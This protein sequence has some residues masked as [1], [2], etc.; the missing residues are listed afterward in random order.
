M[1]IN[2]LC[3]YLL[4]CSILYSPMP[5]GAVVSTNVTVSG[6]RKWAPV[7]STRDDMY[8]PDSCFNDLDADE[9]CCCCRA[10]PCW[11]LDPPACNVTVGQLY[12]EYTDI[13]GSSIF[14]PSGNYTLYEAIH[15]N[16]YLTRFPENMCDFA[17]SLVNVDFSYNRLADISAIRCLKKL[18]TLRLDANRIS[19][20]SNATFSDMEYL[21]IVSLS[22]NIIE[23][24][25]PNT[26]KI[27]NGTV[28]MINFSHNIIETLD[29]TNIIIPGPFC[30]ISYEGCE[31]SEQTNVLDYK[32]NEYNFHGPG[33][34]NLQNTKGKAFLNFSKLGVDDYTQ[35]GNYFK[36]SIEYDGSSIACDCNL[37]PFLAGLGKYASNYWPRLDNNEN[38]TCESPENM[39]GRNLTKIYHGQKF[40]DLTCDLPNCP[41]NCKCTDEPSKDKVIVKCTKQTRMPDFIPVGYWNNYRVEL[42]LSDHSNT[43]SHFTDTS[44]TNRL[45]V[46]NFGDNKIR[47][48]DNAMESLSDNIV[49]TLTNQDMKTIPTSFYKL[50]PNKIDFGTNPVDCSCDNIWVGDWIRN[51]HAHGKLRCSTSYGVFPAEKVTSDFL[52]CPTEETFPIEVIYVLTSLLLLVLVMTSLAYFYK[53]EIMLLKRKFHN[54]RHIQ[55][56]CK[57]DAMVTFSEDNPEVFK[58]MERI[59]HTLRREGYSLFVPFF[60]LIPGGNRECQIAEGVSQSRNYIV[61]Y[62]HKYFHH[63]Y[64]IQEFEIL[65]KHFR[66]DTTKNIIVINFDSLESSEINV[67]RIRAFRKLREDLNFIER[68]TKLFERLKR[69][70]GPPTRKPD[71]EETLV[72][73][74]ESSNDETKSEGQL[75]KVVNRKNKVQWS[76]R[77][78][79]RQTTCNCKYR[80]CYLHG[81]TL[82]NTQY[83]SPGRDRSRKRA[84]NSVPSIPSKRIAYTPRSVMT[85]IPSSS[86]STIDV[87]F[88]EADLDFITPVSIES[89]QG[90]TIET[91]RKETCL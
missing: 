86:A 88:I 59:I 87:N 24:L 44:Y 18:D 2:A 14:V 4:T 17:D 56:E 21:R 5:T 91:D 77:L 28:L 90:E 22:E 50:D 1:A 58:W 29:I 31:I 83:T 7:N 60:D 54:R 64:T 8:C 25:H 6:Y 35:L 49:I 43:I 27:K 61:V 55:V 38:V 11:Q 13:Y 62:C 73:E 72:D 75:E 33:D 36:G 68:E 39:K 82:S 81:D 84:Q 63:E 78:A 66:M 69:R 65:W 20:I 16:G 23:A 40:D 47:N 71:N 34:I 41:H 42:D 45:D 37:Y 10:V 3:L 80:K 12:I 70:L 67:K 53:Y 57:F 19:A 30:N 79:V 52:E 48:I 26:I 85:S 74:Y 51:N 9:R 15:R 76:D 89:F 46:V 32:I